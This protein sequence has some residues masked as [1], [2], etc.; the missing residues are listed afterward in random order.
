MIAPSVPAGA[1]CPAESPCESQLRYS[2]GKHR[3][4]AFVRQKHGATGASALATEHSGFHVADF[5]TGDLEGVAVSDVDPA[6]L[7][8]LVSLIKQAQAR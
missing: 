5:T 2:I 3:V 8:E 7:N 4:S 1:V 6:R